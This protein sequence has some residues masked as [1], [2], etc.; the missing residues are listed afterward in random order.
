MHANEEGC[1]PIPDLP[2]EATRTKIFRHMNTGALLSLGQLC[3][4]QCEVYMNK[5]KC[6]I[7]YKQ[8]LIL[9]GKRDHSTGMWLITNYDTTTQRN[10]RF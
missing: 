7:H 6:D 4:A 10:V 8:K 5:D 1:I 3:D 2:Q 9:Q